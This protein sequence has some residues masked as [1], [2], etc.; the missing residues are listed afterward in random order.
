M[1][2]TESTRRGFLKRS[3]GVMAA[4]AAAPYIWT[5][6]YAKAEDENEIKKEVEALR[7]HR[8]GEDATHLPKPHKGAH[9]YVGG[10][11]RGGAQKA[12]QGV[13]LCRRRHVCAGVQPTERLGNQKGSPKP[14][15]RARPQGNGQALP[16]KHP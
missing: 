14:A 9:Q 2:C 10:E 8:D 15:Q 3:A 1:S 5:S 11:H 4:G 16:Q 6:S 7:R 12:N 13:V